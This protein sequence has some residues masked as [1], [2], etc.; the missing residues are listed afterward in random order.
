MP[1]WTNTNELAGGPEIAWRPDPD[2]PDGKQQVSSFM[3]DI[4]AASAILYEL[5]ELTEENVSEWLY[6]IAM[7][8]LVDLA[9]VV[10]YRNDDGEVKYRALTQEDLEPWFGFKCN[11]YSESRTKWH[12]KFLRIAIDKAGMRGNREVGIPECAA[13]EE[14]GVELKTH[15]KSGDLLCE[16]CLEDAA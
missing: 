2:D 3:H 5:G 10:G 15:R 1:L 13:C 16:F 6:R 4:M 12:E 9:Q 11:V 8:K 7:C 14:R